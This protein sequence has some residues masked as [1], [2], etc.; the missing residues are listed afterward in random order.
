MSEND[1]TTIACSSATKSRLAD[2]CHKDQTYDE[3]LNQLVDMWKKY[4]GLVQQK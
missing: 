1:M 2:I 4:G 3:L